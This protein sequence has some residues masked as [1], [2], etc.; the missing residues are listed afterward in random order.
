MSRFWHESEVPARSLTSVIGGKPENICS[1]RGF[2]ILTHKR[3]WLV[4]RKVRLSAR[5]IRPGRAS[6]LMRKA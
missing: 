5:W 1:Q 4:V 3:H 2:H 6:Y